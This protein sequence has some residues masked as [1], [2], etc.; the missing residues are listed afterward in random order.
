MQEPVAFLGGFFVG[1]L[2][3]DTSDEP[4]RS[5]LEERK[6]EAGV[7]IKSIDQKNTK[8]VLP[9]ILKK[10]GIMMQS[11]LTELKMN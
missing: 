3:V 5:W 2:A 10:T 9:I 1:L 7:L 6:I 11:V 8:H 4:L